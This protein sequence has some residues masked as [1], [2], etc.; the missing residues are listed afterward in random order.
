MVRNITDPVEKIVAEALDAAGIDYLH[1]KDSKTDGLN[2]DF[3]IPDLYVYI[4]CKAFSTDRT[5]AQI[6]DKQVILVQG[7]KA[8]EAFKQLVA[9]PAP[10]VTDELVEIAAAA[11]FERKGGTIE[12]WRA[13]L[14]AALKE[15][16]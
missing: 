2:L 9:R 7:M 14:E 1:E 8:A 5:A 10:V 11:W 13:A 15:V 16:K 4:E 3:Y 6:K 12:N